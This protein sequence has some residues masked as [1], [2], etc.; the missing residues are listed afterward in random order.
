MS[1]NNPIGFD[2]VDFQLDFTKSWKEN[3]E[4]YRKRYFDV[5]GEYPPEPKENEKG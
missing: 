3:W 4:V 5:Y 1:K 2:L